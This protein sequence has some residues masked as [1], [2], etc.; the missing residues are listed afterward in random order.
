MTTPQL[1]LPTELMCCS[2]QYQE[3]AASYSMASRL[4]PCLPNALFKLGNMQFVMQHLHEAVI[5]YQQA[6]EVRWKLQFALL[7]SFAWLLIVAD[8]AAAESLTSSCR[9][10]SAWGMIS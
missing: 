5:S 7:L 8:H 1:G 4:D 2:K 3:A 6:L 10:L 9:L